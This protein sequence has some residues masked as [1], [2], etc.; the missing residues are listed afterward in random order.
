[1]AINCISWTLTSVA[2]YSSV[3][4]NP[5]V[6]INIKRLREKPAGLKFKPTLGI[7][8]LVAI[9]WRKHTCG[10]S[11]NIDAQTMRGVEWC[12]AA[13]ASV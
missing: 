6:K 8:S 13:S 1:M 12:L 9:S 5:L 3:V 7:P 10:E 2:Y 11:L 4:F